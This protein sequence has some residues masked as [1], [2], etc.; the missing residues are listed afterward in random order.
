MNRVVLLRRLGRAAIGAGWSL[1]LRLVTIPAITG[2][3]L[4]AAGGVLTLDD[5]LQPAVLASGV[6]VSVALRF[7]D[8]LMVEFALFPAVVNFMKGLQK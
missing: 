4:L 3:M 2:A 7:F 5:L 8:N 1:P 6:A